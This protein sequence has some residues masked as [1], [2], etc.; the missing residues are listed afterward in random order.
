MEISRLFP[1]FITHSLHTVVQ[2]VLYISKSL[3]RSIT[4]KRL[5]LCVSHSVL[6][7]LYVLLS[8]RGATQDTPLGRFSLYVPNP[9]VWSNPRLSHTRKAK[10][11]GYMMNAVG[12]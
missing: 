1:S 8:D 4:L 7:P 11:D 10:G 12:S 9:V 6:S 3:S 5:G 2:P